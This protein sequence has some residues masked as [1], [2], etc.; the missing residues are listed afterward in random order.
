L[1]KKFVEAKKNKSKTVT[2]WGTGK[3]TREFLFVDDAADAIILAT[4][5][6]NKPEPVNIGSSFEISIKELAEKIK[7]ITEFKGKIIWDSSKPDGQ[8]RRKLD[9]SR[10]KTEFGFESQISFSKGLKK[11]IDW[12]L[13]NV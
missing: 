1:I 3:P 11:T 7:D 9:T 2:V 6:Y 10:A 8:P 5:K 13:K 12:Y 4:E